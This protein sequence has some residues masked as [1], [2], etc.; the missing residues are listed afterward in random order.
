MTLPIK[1][2]NLNKE[3][4]V[5]TI[6][7]CR[8]K[9]TEQEK[10]DYYATQHL[11]PLLLAFRHCIGDTCDSEVSY[12]AYMVYVLF[13]VISVTRLCLVYWNK[14][15][16]L[17]RHY[18]NTV[19]TPEE[20]QKVLIRLAKENYWEI[21]LCNKQQFIADDICFRK[22]VYGLQQSLYFYQFPLQSPL[23]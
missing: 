8:I 7:D 2:F 17:K 19:L 13:P 16:T 11:Y 15:N 18:I 3:L 6:K 21:I 1:E 12:G 20:H 14:K 5:R 4:L 9:L 10:N 22:P 23:P